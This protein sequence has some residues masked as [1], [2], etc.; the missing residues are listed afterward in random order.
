MA[1][2]GADRAWTFQRI[3]PRPPGRSCQDPRCRGQK[4]APS[5]V[6]LIVTRH[7]LC[8][9]GSL[10]WTLRHLTPL[11][12]TQ[13]SKLSLDLLRAPPDLVGVSLGPSRPH[14]SLASTPDA[15]QGW[16]SHSALPAPPGWRDS[17]PQ[18]FGLC[19]SFCFEDLSRLFTR[20]VPTGFSEFNLK[21][22]AWRFRS[23]SQSHY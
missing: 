8:C 20:P 23:D 4:I 21:S 14:C 17:P 15:P 10:G 12:G 9:V 3:L 2:K 22:P 5:C 11:L 16:C 6:R 13:L 1:N 18:R 7:L 19:C